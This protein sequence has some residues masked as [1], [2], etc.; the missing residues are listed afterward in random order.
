[1]RVLLSLV[2]FVSC[3]SFS[4]SPDTKL[5][6]EEASG[7]EFP[8]TGPPGTALFGAEPSDTETKEAPITKEEKL[9]LC[10]G[11]WM[12]M[13]GE[14]LSRCLSIVKPNRTLLKCMNTAL[15]CQKDKWTECEQNIDKIQVHDNT[16]SRRAVISWKNF[17]SF[18]LQAKAFW[19][20]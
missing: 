20:I 18:R 15:N 11:H 5:F 3:L 12:Y 14:W 19:F 13:C 7:A 2:F 17:I 6:A 8:D 10:K 1:M 9:I 4:K 16:S